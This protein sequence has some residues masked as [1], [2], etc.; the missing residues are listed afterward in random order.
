METREQPRIQTRRL[1]YGRAKAARHARHATFPFLSAPPRPAPRP[2]ALR[3]G[4]CTATSVL[5]LEL[6]LPDPFRRSNDQHQ[7]G[8]LRLSLL[9]KTALADRTEGSIARDPRVIPTDL[10]EKGKRTG[11]FRGR[12]FHSD[13]PRKIQVEPVRCFHRLSEDSMIARLRVRT[14][15]MLS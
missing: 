14:T 3:P 6:T 15:R 12:R 5:Q 13:A 8:T 11:A 1:P 4:T 2:L 10:Q 7:R 9:P